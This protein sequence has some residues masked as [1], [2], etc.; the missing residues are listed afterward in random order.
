MNISP[1]QH[2]LDLGFI[3]SRKKKKEGKTKISKIDLGPK[4][5]ILR[6]DPSVYRK[7]NTSGSDVSDVEI[8]K[9]RT[10]TRTRTGKNDHV[11]SQ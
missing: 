8:Y 11:N 10:R 2:D 4:T 5:A 3:H 7:K 9:T 1:D 6:P